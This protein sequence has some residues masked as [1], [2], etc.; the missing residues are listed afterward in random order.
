[1]ILFNTCTIFLVYL[2]VPV[3]FMGAVSITH[4]D[5]YLTGHVLEKLPLAKFGWLSC[6][7]ACEQD[8][9]CI[10]YHFN[11]MAGTC[12]L[13]ADGLGTDCGAEELLIYQPGIIFHQIRVRSIIL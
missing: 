10:S 9:R 4:K 8:P 7:V 3:Y 6:T 13:I 1:M 2:T 5:K 11:S 12:E